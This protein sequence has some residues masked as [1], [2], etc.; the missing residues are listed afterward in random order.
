V[1]VLKGPGA[2][3]NETV[4]TKA[5]VLPLIVHISG[6]VDSGRLCLPPKLAH[7]NFP[8]AGRLGRSGEPAFAV[9]QT[10]LRQQSAH[11]V[12]GRN[13][14]QVAKMALRISARGCTTAPN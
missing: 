5:A 10:N 2:S 8:F 14:D 13:A 1:T 12:G 7:W 3:P 4:F 11:Q 6:K 9:T